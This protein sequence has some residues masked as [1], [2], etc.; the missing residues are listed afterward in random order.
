MSFISS[1]PYNNPNKGLL[2]NRIVFLLLILML[3]FS[4]SFSQIPAGYYDPAIGLTG[5]FLQ[6][7]LHDI[8][9]D[10]TVKSYSYLWTAFQS[11]DAKPNGTV[12]DMYSVR[13]KR[14]KTSDSGILLQKDKKKQPSHK[15]AHLQAPTHRLTLQ[16][17]KELF[18]CRHATL[19]ITFRQ[20]LSIP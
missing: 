17:A 15:T 2:G 10:H 8:I 20:I 11:T 18:S 7:A 14:R 13:H 9:K 4:R 6:Q 1:K 19:F 5:T 16:L 3:P 12:W